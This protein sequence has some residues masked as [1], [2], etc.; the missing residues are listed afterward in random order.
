MTKT[1]HE[2]VAH[3]GMAAAYLDQM[4]YALAGLVKNLPKAGVTDLNELLLIGQATER[5]GKMMLAETKK[6]WNEAE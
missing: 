4:T 5:L 1:E 6:T 2:K 3:M